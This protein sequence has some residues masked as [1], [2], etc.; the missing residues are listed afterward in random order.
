[1][2]V[3][4]G[5]AKMEAK[6]DYYHNLS[7]ESKAKF[8]EHVYKSKTGQ[9]F[10]ERAANNELSQSP[11]LGNSSV[12]NAQRLY[13][14]KPQTKMNKFSTEPTRLKEPTLR[15]KARGAFNKSPHW[16]RLV[17]EAADNAGF[18]SVIEIWCQIC[19][20]DTKISK[21]SPYAIPGDQHCVDR[22]PR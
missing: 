5:L 9:L 16:K 17:R 20:E 1:M 4:A 10:G 14:L 13:K 7:H 6:H 22:F 8:E 11:I 18:P 15:R 21:R 12:E 3:A 19:R 2:A